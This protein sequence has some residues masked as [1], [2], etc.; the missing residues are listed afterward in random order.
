MSSG[1]ATIERCRG[2]RAG[3]GAGRR[4]APRRGHPGL[5]RQ[6]STRWPCRARARPVAPG[7][8]PTAVSVAAPGRGAAPRQRRIRREP[9]ARPR[10]GPVAG[11]GGRPGPV[12]SALG[13]L[14]LPS[15]P[16]ACCGGGS[17][18]CGCG[19][20][21]WPGGPPG[22]AVRPRAVVGDDVQHLRGRRPHGRGVP[23]TGAGV[24]GGAAA[25][26]GD[27]PSR[28]PAPWCWPKRCDRPGRSGACPWAAWPSARHRAR[29]PARPGS[30]DHCCWWASSGWAAGASAILATAVIGRVD[31]ARSGAAPSSRGA[32]R[33]AAGPVAAGLAALAVV[34]ASAVVGGGG[35]R[36]RPGHPHRCG[37]A[38][39]QGGGVR[40]LRKS[41]VD[42]ATVTAAQFAATS[43]IASHDEGRPPSLVVWPED[44]VSLDT[45]IDGTS[46]E[47]QLAALAVRLH[48]TLLVG[49]TE[50]VSAQTFRNEIVAF[51]PAGK[52]VARFEKVHRVPFGEYIPFRG[53]FKHLANL[54]SVPLD[55]IPGHGNGVLHTPVGPL[56]TLV[57]L[58][59]L[60]RPTRAGRHARRCTAPRRP[61]QHLVLPHEPG[62]DPGD[63]GRPAAGDLRRARR[64][65]GG[66]RPASAPSSTTGAASW[67]APTSAVRAV[68]VRDVALRTGRTIYERVG[69]LPVLGAVG[70]P[71]GGGMAHRLQ[72]PTPIPS[73]RTGAGASAGTARSASDAAGGPSQLSAPDCRRA[74]RR[75]A[76]TAA[77]RGGP[78]PSGACRP[79]SRPRS[80]RPARACGSGRAARCRWCAR[81]A[82][83]APRGR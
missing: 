22:W 56:G 80:A 45:L 35:S 32:G 24:C 69:D 30:A 29:W 66:A 20:A 67:R 13:I 59:G 8:K 15:P 44:V 76:P 11:G 58:R 81:S 28:W 50:T 47:S 23:G 1:S 4:R 34:A 82:R 31:R 48:A 60:L 71:R 54:S 40:G 77:R 49:V 55:A 3:L 68:I 53:F 39:V 72:Q 79:S 63:R 78:P 12:A 17:G 65:P 42:P 51:S 41:E 26:A 19:P 46:T 57:S 36:R 52:L 74:R 64:G 73:A 61:H 83:S 2:P 21:C 10:R 75:S 70:A 5:H 38:A 7:A 43:E 37:C 9:A 16:R 33:G 25:G 14:G 18:A 62:A 27:A 6:R